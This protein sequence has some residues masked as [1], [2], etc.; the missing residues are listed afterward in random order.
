MIIDQLKNAALYFGTHARMEQAFRYLQKTDFSKIDP[1][2]YEIEGT[3]LFA[4]IQQYDTK[5]KEKGRWEAHRKYIDV[6]YVF[7][8]TELF[9]YAHLGQL[10]SVAFDEAKDFHE[11]KGSGDFLRV[12]AGMFLVLF[13][14]DA[15][16]PGI[17]VSAPE[18]VKKVVVKVLAS[19]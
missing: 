13:P 8:G 3:N 11:L 14:H 17:S 6:Q 16:M 2:K 15:H 9:G 19:K 18:P 4:L 1:G 7:S 12:P 5:A 10:Q